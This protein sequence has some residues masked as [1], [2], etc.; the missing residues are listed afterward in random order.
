MVVEKP[1]RVMCSLVSL[2]K[3]VCSSLLA[4]CGLSE[5]LGIDWLWGEEVVLYFILTTLKVS[6]GS[7]AR[8][9]S[10]PETSEEMNETRAVR[11][12]RNSFREQPLWFWVL[13]LSAALR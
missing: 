12:I 7:A 4:S 13:G 11:L 10:T 9:R 8:V 5:A 1:R 2:V 3:P 6:L